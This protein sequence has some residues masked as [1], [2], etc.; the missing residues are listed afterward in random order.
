MS[1]GSTMKHLRTRAGGLLLAGAA[2]LP[3]A[4]CS[5]RQGPASPPAATADATAAPAA[6]P[7]A[8]ALVERGEYL[9]R[10]GDCMACHSV[11]GKPAYAG[12]LA[13]RS[14]VGTI[15]S[16]NITPDPV[17]GIG[18]YTEQ[19]FADAV[20]KGIRADGQHLYPAMPYPDY[21]RID[22]QDMHALYAYFLHGVKPSGEQPQ[23]T[24]LHFPFS[25]RWGMRFWNYAFADDKPFVAPANAG[26][27]LARG[28]YLVQGLGHCGSCHTPRGFAM[29]QKTFNDADA[30]FL[31]GGDL[32]G[33]SAPSL[34]GLPHWSK[35]QIVDYLG[36]GRNSVAAVAGEMTSVVANSTSHLSDADLGAIAVYLQSLQPSGPARTADDAASRATAARL[37]AAVGLNEGQRLYLD[38]CSACHFVDGRGGPRV[39]PRIDGAS[40]VNA[41]QP[42]GL[43]RLILDGAATPSTARAPAVLPMPGFADRL[44]DREV[45]DLATFLRSGWANRAGAVSEA[46]VAKARKSLHRD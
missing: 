10:A 21:A 33:W 35:E 30:S 40:I 31:A 34:R 6:A 39:F 23:Q 1:G 8:R 24:D 16:T 2:A 7:Q 4:A 29:N 38:N 18:R 9:A 11:P 12:G 3:L 5:D 44:S 14:G 13:I 46:Q 22:D 45:A 37:T 20:R 17:A 26:G 43:I 25:Q 15:Y 28:A 36:T 32:D 19:Q 41:D 42:G 27:E